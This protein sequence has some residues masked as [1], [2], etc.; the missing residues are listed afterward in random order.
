M[1]YAKEYDSPNGKLYS[2][3]A[4]DENER[5]LARQNHDVLSK[6]DGKYVKAHGN[7]HDVEKVCSENSDKMVYVETMQTYHERHFRIVQNPDNLSTAEL[8]LIVDGGSLCF[9]FSGSQTYIDI[10]TD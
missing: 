6:L 2:C 4:F 7:W 1:S 5:E 9:G 10:Y 8:A 3:W